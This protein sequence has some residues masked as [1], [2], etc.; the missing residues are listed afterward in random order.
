MPRNEKTIYLTFDD[1]PHPD[2]TPF[3]LNELKK[4]NAKGSF[5]CLG[6]NVAL[7]PQTY[8]QIIDEGHAVGNHTHNHPNGWEV[9][10]EEYVQDISKA[11]EYIQSNLFRP[12]YG[13]IKKEQ[14][15][16]VKKA[17]NNEQTKIIMWDVLSADFDTEFS[18]QQC[19]NNVLKNSGNGSIVVFHDSEK[20]FRNLEYSFPRALKQFAD[21]GYDFKKIE[22]PVIK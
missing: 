19:L 5:F 9:S 18:P 16:K 22:F 15:K 6:N 11:A 3:V 8:Q 10:T 1:G 7:Y 14:S 13:R 2:I 4:Y 12:P 21:E 20:A 17:M